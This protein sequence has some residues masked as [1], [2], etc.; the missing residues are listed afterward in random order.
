[1][2]VREPLF[3]IAAAGH[4]RPMKADNSGEVWVRMKRGKKGRERAPRLNRGGKE[5]CDEQAGQ[6]EIPCVS[7]KDGRSC[8]TMEKKIKRREKERER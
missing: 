1:M 5:Y 7:E 8:W 2:K 4:R 3:A 6:R